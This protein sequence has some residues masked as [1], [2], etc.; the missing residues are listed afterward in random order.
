MEKF[1][2]KFSNLFIW[3]SYKKCERF[4]RS[5]CYVV[6]VCVCFIKCLSVKMSENLLV[7][8]GM[9]LFVWLFFFQIVCSIRKRSRRFQS[10]LSWVDIVCRWMDTEPS[11]TIELN[12]ELTLHKSERAKTQ[13]IG[14]TVRRKLFVF[15]RYLSLTDRIIE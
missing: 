5:L 3:C 6:F 13:K 2:D 11:D 7:A 10:A 14:K 9:H 12:S 15:L 8:I 4:K 1:G